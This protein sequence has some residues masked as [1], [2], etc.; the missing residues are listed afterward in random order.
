VQKLLVPEKDEMEQVHQR[1]CLEFYLN[2]VQGTSKRT[3]VLIFVS[4]ME[5]KAVILAD[6]GISSKLPPETWDHLL[7][8]FRVKLNQGQWVEGFTEAIRECGKHL[9][10]HFPISTPSG[11]QLK[12][13][14]V[15]KE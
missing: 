12:N 13:H 10:T 8:D 5:K 9:K 1:A 4:V 7:V 15:V 11:N 2:R 3:G 14:L 6:E